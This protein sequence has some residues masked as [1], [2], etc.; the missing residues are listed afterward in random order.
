MDAAIS[1]RCRKRDRLRILVCPRSWIRIG[2]VIA[3]TATPIACSLVTSLDALTGGALPEDSSIDSSLVDVVRDDA[4]S[5]AASGDADTCDADLASDPD[6]CGR[7]GRSCFSGGC[8]AGLCSYVQVTQ[9]GYDLAYQDGFVYASTGDG[10]V[11]IDVSSDLVSPLVAHQAQG[12]GIGV[13]APFVV[14]ASNDQHI[15]RMLLDG[16]SMKAL[17]DSGATNIMT[18]VANAT[19]VLWINPTSGLVE[20]T[21]MVDGGAPTVFDNLAPGAYGYLRGDDHNLVVFTDTQHVAQINLT[22]LTRAASAV[23]HGNFLGFGG[24]VAYFNDDHNVYSLTIGSSDVTTVATVP[25][26]TGTIAAIAGDDNGPAWM[27][28]SPDASTMALEGCGDPKC[29][30]GPVQLAPTHAAFNINAMIVTPDSVFLS[31]P[32]I[33]TGATVRVAR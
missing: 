22:T 32:I 18:L 16:G 31:G 7:C 27:V 11:A 28:A 5:D 12:T 19:D 30:T 33:A 26:E 2:F 9:L 24:T 20:H 15:Y 29:S 17:A 1:H 23:A 13:A 25:V 3:A 10:V 4:T 6:N 21:S 14:W 8:E